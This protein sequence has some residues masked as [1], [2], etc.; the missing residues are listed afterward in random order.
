MQHTPW[1][2]LR[3]QAERFPFLAVA[4]R[5][6]RGVWLLHTSTPVMTRYGFKLVGNPAM[7][8]GT[9]EPDETR[10]LE[11]SLA[12]ADTFVD[13]GAN[14]GYFSCLARSL[15][16]RVVA[17][18]PLAENLDYL[19][20]NLLLNGFDD[21]EVFPLGLAERPG[22]RTLLEVQPLPRS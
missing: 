12:K 2:A 10:F 7:Q 17:V 18:E 19:F 13:I 22:L 9:F 20:R 11:S 3:R 1:R 6:I 21:V 14:I 4:Y 15:G 5:K 16:K 8:S